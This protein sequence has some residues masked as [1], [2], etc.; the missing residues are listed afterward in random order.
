LLHPV[1]VNRT[2]V[3]ELTPSPTVGVT[4]AAYNNVNEL[5]GLSGGGAVRFHG[6]TDRPVLPVTMNGGAISA[7]MLSTQNFIANPIL[8]TGNNAE[9]VT[10]TPGGGTG[11]STTNT[12][13]I[14]ATGPGSSTLSYD[15]NGNMLSDGTNTY[16]WDVEN[17][18]IKITYPGSGNNSQFT[19]DPLG[20][21]V[22]IVETVSSS[23]TSTK[24]FIWCGNN[25]CET[26]D[27]S[28]NVTA[29]FFSKGE[30]I[31]GTSYYYTRTHDFS[32]REMTNSSGTIVWQQS[33]D[34]YGVPTTLV[35][36][37]PADMGYAGYYLH[38]R[39][40]LNL[41][42]TRAY[43]A[44]LGRFI[45]RDPIGLSGGVNLYG[46]VG[47]NPIS[48]A[49]PM[50]WAPAYLPP[51]T[52]MPDPAGNPLQGGISEDAPI[53]GGTGGF[54]GSCNGSSS[55]APNGGSPPLLAQASGG[56]GGGGDGGG[57]GGGGTG[58]PPDAIPLNTN[59]ATYILEED[60]NHIISKHTGAAPYSNYYPG[61]TW[62]ALQLIIEKTV[63]RGFASQNPHEWMGGTIYR[64]IFAVP[65]GTRNVTSSG[66][67]GIF[68]GPRVMVPSF[69]NSV[70]VLPDGHVKS[71]FPA[72]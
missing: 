38:Q 26:R 48:F 31:S 64:D 11:S 21:C 2:R 41:T 3:F 44:S 69:W 1:F 61:T 54:G 10:A 72:W 56:D 66:P 5:T 58:W 68:P 12:Y 22:K 65:I 53:P 8:T 18:L 19:Y 60:I 52:P 16:A 47:G 62:P 23:V 67:F 71:A 51:M 55:G 63:T 17:R 25:R 7:T 29:Q 46:Y 39:S 15:K 13:Q 59:P 35:S 43:N 36:T 49:D 37:T 6:T 45:N 42:R 70:I 27:A 30:T 4:Q 28:G 33:F 40:G 20:R 34:P 14:S 50:G 57:G 9:T 24:Q 32:V